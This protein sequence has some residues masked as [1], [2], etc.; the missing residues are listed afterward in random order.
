MAARVDGLGADCRFGRA[1]PVLYTTDASEVSDLE[2]EHEAA[3]R[4][5][6]PSTLT[7]ETDL[8][9]PVVQALRFDDQAHF[10]AASYTAALARTLAERG[11]QI[12]ERTRAMGVDEGADRVTVKTEHGDV[13]ADHV[14]IATQLPFL[15]LGGFFPTPRP[16]RATAAAGIGRA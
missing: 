14:V 12:V 2:F 16:Q 3:T 15:D 8:P 9:F 4:L 1:P 13:R 7:T 6:L 11:V 5:G 10:H